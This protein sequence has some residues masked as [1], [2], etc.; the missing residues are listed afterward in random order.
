MFDKQ[1]VFYV[2]STHGYLTETALNVDGKVSAFASTWTLLW[3]SR[4]HPKVK[5]FT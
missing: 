3:N 1:G 2:S 4:T 5:V